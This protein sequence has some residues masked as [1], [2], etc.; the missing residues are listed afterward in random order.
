MRSKEAL[1]SENA[2]LSRLSDKQ[3]KAVDAAME[4]IKQL[5]TQTVCFVDDG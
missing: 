4:Q 3:Q 1:A 5:Q 2:V